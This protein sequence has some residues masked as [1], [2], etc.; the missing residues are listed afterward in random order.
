MLNRIFFLKY[1]LILFT[2]FAAV[3]IA[4][5]DPL[6]SIPAGNLQMRES[7]YINQGGVSLGTTGGSLAVARSE[8]TLWSSNT[9][10]SC[11]LCLAN[12]QSNGVFS[13]TNVSTSS[14]VFAT[15]TSGST[16]L[17]FSDIWPYFQIVNGSTNWSPLT[18]AP[19]VTGNVLAT[20]P[21]TPLTGDWSSTFSVPAP[22]GST[23]VTAV[24]QVPH[25]SGTN[26]GVTLSPPAMG[27]GSYPSNPADY[28]SYSVKQAVTGGYGTLQFPLSSGSPVTYNFASSTYWTIG[29][30]SNPNGWGGVVSDITIDGNG[31]IL[32]FSAPISAGMIPA[33]YGII[34][35]GTQRVLLKNFVIDWPSLTAASLGTIQSGGGG[36]YLQVSSYP[37]SNPTVASFSKWNTT[38]GSWAFNIQGQPL[39]IFFSSGGYPSPTCSGSPTATC[40]YSGGTN[41]FNSFTAGTTVIVRYLTGGG[42][43][44]I[45]S[46]GNDVTI[47][48]VTVNASTGGGIL[49]GAVRGIAINNC[50]IK[51][52]SGSGRILSSYADAINVI[53]S[54]G[55]ISIQNNDIENQGD[56][57]LNIKG[58]LQSLTGSSVTGSGTQLNPTFM[59]P[60][61]VVGDVIGFFDQNVAYLGSATV[62]A[63]SCSTPS[64]TFNHSITSYTNPLS[65]GT[66]TVFTDLTQSSSRYVVA[67]NTFKNHRG[68]AMLLQGPYGSVSGNT[69]SGQSF[70]PVL[71]L[72]D[73][74]QFQEGPGVD[75]LTFSGNTISGAGVSNGLAGAVTVLADTPN[76]TGQS[77][78]GAF[79]A[80]PATVHQNVSISSNTISNMPGPSI[81]VSSANGVS[82]TSNNICNVNTAA[83]SYNNL[84]PWGLSGTS[85][86]LLIY[87]AESVIVSGNQV[88]TIAGCGSTT[89]SGG[90]FQVDKTSAI[91][92][93]CGG[94]NTCV[95]Q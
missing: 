84:V 51:I 42:G 16:L 31:S 13:L 22:G 44:V 76:T 78:S 46:G 35:Q 59:S 65:G 50:T 80:S 61:P 38:T 1:N 10:G 8:L 70:S 93:T 18:P 9:A 43:A 55:D 85:A 89:G 56:D 68:R 91:G 27:T 20:S 69:I 90:S 15:A 37:S 34:L 26:A 77:S 71:I 36:N 25:P 21:I 23:S 75:G 79:V 63:V 19:F 62:T 32:N 86:S 28:F 7:E 41:Y 3:A 60:C 72:A 40:T 11:T 5:A 66:A 92:V 48:N 81:V 2:S 64:I 14:T 52:P 95:V 39:E 74:W 88:N 6:V 87:E 67:N 33:S 4:S 47:Q 73:S 24:V 53:N 94:G 83:S 30:D 49:A 82:V 29:Y 12:F 57:G 17:S 54:S 45:P 58:A